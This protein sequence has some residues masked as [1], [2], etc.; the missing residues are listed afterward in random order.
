MC[1][2]LFWLGGVGCWIPLGL[3]QAGLLAVFVSLFSYPPLGEKKKKKRQQTLLFFSTF[4]SFFYTFPPPKSA[5]S[6]QQTQFLETLLQLKKPNLGLL[7]CFIKKMMFY[8]A[9]KVTG[10]DRCSCSSAFPG[11]L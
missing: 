11:V 6:K 1:Q 8:E 9:R 2:A 3:T 5:S 4:F 7:R 10:S